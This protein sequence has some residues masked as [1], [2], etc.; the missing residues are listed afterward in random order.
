MSQAKVFTVR[1]TVD[2]DLDSIFV[3]SVENFGTK[4]AEKYVTDLIDSFQRLADN[5]RIGRDCS[6]IKPNLYVLDV[7]LPTW[8]FI[9]QREVVYPSIGY[10]IILWTTDDISIRAAQRGVILVNITS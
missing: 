10:Y 5:Y 9:S 8:S 4:R 2:K 7:V 1:E 6:Y 3:Y